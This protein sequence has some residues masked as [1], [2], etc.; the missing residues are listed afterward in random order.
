MFVPLEC[1]TLGSSFAPGSPA[2]P[3]RAPAFG[4]S[5]CSPRKP[6]PPPGADRTCGYS[7]PQRWRPFWV[8]LRWVS[9]PTPAPGA[10][11]PSTL[12]PAWREAR[13]S[14]GTAAAPRPSP[15][16]SRMRCVPACRARGFPGGSAGKESEKEEMKN[17][18]V[19]R[20]KEILKIK[21]EINAKE[22]KRP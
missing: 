15:A 19:S 2:L 10:R 7:W 20:R 12:R 18:R 4:T 11:S 16:G 3:R 21:A 8:D 13:Q 1:L 22:K 5:R 14:A 6:W 17:P 9:V